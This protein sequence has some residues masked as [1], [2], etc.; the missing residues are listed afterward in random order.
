MRTPVRDVAADEHP[1]GQPHKAEGA[2]EEQQGARPAR[3]R[4]G[5]Q[6]QHRARRAQVHPRGGQRNCPRAFVRRHPLFTQ[7]TRPQQVSELPL[8]CVEHGM[9][10][11]KST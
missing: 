10:A 5:R 7:C 1:G 3:G 6:R 11:A 2:V 8:S 9:H 4:N